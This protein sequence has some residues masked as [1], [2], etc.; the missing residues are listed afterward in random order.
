MS[1]VQELR[2]LANRAE[3]HQGLTAWQTLQWNRLVKKITSPQAIMITHGTNADK[4]RQFVKQLRANSANPAANV[5]LLGSTLDWVREVINEGQ[6]NRSKDVSKAWRK[7]IK[8]QVARSGVSSAAYAFVKRTE[9]NPDIVSV[10]RVVRTAAPQD[11]VE[12]DLEEWEKVWRALEEHASQPWR[13]DGYNAH[14]HHR[15]PELTVEDL[16]RAARTFPAYTGIGVDAWSPNAIGWLSDVTLEALAKYLQTLE[17]RRVWPAQVSTSLIHVIPKAA[18]GRRPIGI[19][20]S[21]VRVWERARKTELQTWRDRNKREYNF[22]A[23]NK[24]AEKKQCEH[25]PYSRR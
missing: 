3:T 10:C 25:N 2:A 6:A 22:M 9:E 21:V 24:G 23:A 15:M 14:E 1:R 12:L 20:A 11:V 7:W 4:W 16:R 18:G 5:G 17:A 8:Q 13:D 19:L